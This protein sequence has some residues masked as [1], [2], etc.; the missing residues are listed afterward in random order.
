MCQG[1]PLA[2][3]AILAAPSVLLNKIAGHRLP[4]I[5]MLKASDAPAWYAIPPGSRVMGSYRAPASF[6]GCVRSA[7][8][9]HNET[10]NIHTHLWPGLYVLYRL[11]T[12]RDETLYL[13]AS[14]D[15]RFCI[16]SGLFG[17]AALFLASAVAHTFCI[18][19]QRVFQVCWTLDFMSIVLVNLSHQF[20]DSFLL[21]K[22]ILGSRILFV[23]ALTI[24]AAFALHCLWQI[25][26]LPDTGPYWGLMYPLISSVGLTPILVIA[27]SRS[28]AILVKCSTA[29]AMCSVMI[30][31]AG[32]VFFKGRVPEVLCNPRGIFDTVN[33]H[34]WHHVCIAASIFAAM[35]AMPLLWQLE[36]RE[37]PKL[38][39]TVPWGT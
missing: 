3:P 23:A 17:S 26:T 18:L 38:S 9:W 12:I 34:V 22:I 14:D 31:I 35:E 1:G 6:A 7:F 2:G 21:F 29:S 4:L 24:E 19:N 20:L 5:P 25:G 15:A 39:T 37:M 28:E 30:L 10:L 16:L 27:A 36:Y 11:L 13:N 8:E 33:S 32:G